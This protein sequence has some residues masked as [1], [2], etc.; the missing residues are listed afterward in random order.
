MEQ[1][2]KLEE[3]LKQ[4]VKERDP[5]RIIRLTIIVLIFTLGIFLV[6]AAFAPLE[7]GAPA[8]GFVTVANYRKVVQHQYGGTVKDILVHEGEEVKKGQVLIRLE[9]SDLKAQFAQ[10]K[11]EYVS[12]LA[13]Y[14]RLQAEKYFLPRII[15]PPEVLEM[16]DTPEIK[17]VIQ[18]QNE[19]FQARRAKLE[20][21]KKIIMESI[22][23]FRSYAKN[24]EAQKHYYREQLALVEKQIKSL[25]D[26]SEEGYYPKNRLLELQRQAEAL[27]AQI[28]ETQ[29]NQVRAEASVKEYLM[30][31]SAIEKDY[32]KEVETELADIEKKLMA[33][34]EIYEAI[35][36]KLE[37]T[38]ITA[39]EDGIVMNL[40][41]HT[42][43]G[44]I[45]PAEP[46]LEIVPKNAE[47]IVE[48]KL[49]PSHIEDVKVGQP[50]DLRFVA[51]DPKK[52][53]VLTGKLIYVSPDILY[54]EAQGTKIPYYLLRA[55]IDKESLKEIK[56][57]N[58]EITP[59]MPVQVIVKT[60][61]RTFLS[62]LFK[63]FLDRMAAAFLK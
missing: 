28:A 8:N 11:A 27:R 35:K 6:W 3:E 56:K 13:I 29:A 59:G 44:V 39:P 50:V 58:K 49:S 40:R 7:Q 31:L 10:V 32:L 4:E 1:E 62:Y 55:R 5:H 20:A 22:E 37:K 19:V 30:R 34:K 46:I 23:G 18:V 57:F 48:A 24:L 33:L 9:D 61:K 26:L 42:I 16:K 25:K 43:G 63:P 51:L 54:D 38:E 17:K 52:T 60:G 21:D 47:L 53:P 36:D 2:V 45:R 15:Y 41:V 12:A 14:T